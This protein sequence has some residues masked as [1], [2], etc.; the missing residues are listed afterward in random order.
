MSF[1][2][3]FQPLP[4]CVHTLGRKNTDHRVVL[5][6]DSE[7]MDNSGMSVPEKMEDQ[8]FLRLT[9]IYPLT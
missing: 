7:M 3:L 9:R 1:S 6:D 2:A 8:T 5:E 4:H